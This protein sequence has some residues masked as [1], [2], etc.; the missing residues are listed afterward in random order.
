MAGRSQGGPGARGVPSG[1]PGLDFRSPRAPFQVQFLRI[2]GYVFVYFFG[3]SS[4]SLFDAVLAPSGARFGIILDPFSYQIL[5]VKS[6]TFS[7]TFLERMWEPP[8]TTTGSK[9]WIFIVLSF[10]IECRAFRVWERP[11]VVLEAK[12]EPKWRSKSTK[13]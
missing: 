1:A 3:A 4:A 11:G 13:K 9:S 6:A 5:S 7:R 2:F 8:A 12:M 10:K